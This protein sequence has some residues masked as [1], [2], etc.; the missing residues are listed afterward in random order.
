MASSG[1]NLLLESAA[2]QK[3]STKK[4]LHRPVKTHIHIRRS[5]PLEPADISDMCTE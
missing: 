5:I 4:K 2:A 3:R 1:Y